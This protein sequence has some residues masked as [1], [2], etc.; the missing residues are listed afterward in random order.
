MN[1]ISNDFTHGV[2]NIMTEDVFVKIGVIGEFT[3]EDL[4][5]FPKGNVGL[6]FQK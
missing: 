3:D 1:I 2:T 6:L 5:L 4:L